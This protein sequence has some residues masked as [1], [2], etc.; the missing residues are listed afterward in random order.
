MRLTHLGRR[1]RGRLSCLPRGAPGAPTTSTASPAPPPPP[2]RRVPQRSTTTQ[3]LTYRH[4][5]HHSS[6][7]QTELEERAGAA[8]G[9][10]GAAGAEGAEGAAA[11][12]GQARGAT[13]TAV[14]V[15]EQTVFSSRF[16]TRGALTRVKTAIPS[17]KSS[18]REGSRATSVKCASACSTPFALMHTRGRKRWRG[19]VC[20]HSFLEMFVVYYE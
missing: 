19:V 5:M 13:R 9:A 12:G 15:R 14:F 18:R 2:P 20:A 3:H 10:G 11:M 8:G 4:T 1:P 7:P 6:N 16:R 17:P